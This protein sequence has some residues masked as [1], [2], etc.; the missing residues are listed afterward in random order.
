L[1]VRLGCFTNLVSCAEGHKLGTAAH[2]QPRSTVAASSSSLLGLQA[3]LRVANIALA[4]EKACAEA[5]KE[6]LA[7]SKMLVATSKMLV[8]S[9]QNEVDY[10]KT[11]Q[12]RL[13]IKI[14]KHE[15]QYCTRTVMHGLLRLAFPSSK[16]TGGTM[17]AEFLRNHVL[18]TKDD[19]CKKLSKEAQLLFDETV[20]CAEFKSLEKTTPS[21]WVTTFKEL[22]GTFN[23]NQHALPE[24]D[25]LFKEA[26]VACGGGNVD[27]MFSHVIVIA[28]IQKR[29][30]ARN[31][32]I[33]PSAFNDVAVLSP[34]L[35]RVVG[36]ITGGKFHPIPPQPPAAAA[37][38]SS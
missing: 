6:T 28:M 38:A 22:Y 11:E 17:Y 16:A 31:T 4:S 27:R 36:R 25:E 37:A 24:F 30:M 10:L 5:M 1:R 20:Q 35:R 3:D 18:L 21:S 7:T 12:D 34:D 9:K 32:E 15:M 13:F 8:E 33:L 2:S 26:G 14:A 23:D 29:C 19:N